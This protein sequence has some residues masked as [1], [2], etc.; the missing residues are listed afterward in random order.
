M[1]CCTFKLHKWSEWQDT[2][3][4]VDLVVKSLFSKGIPIEGTE[5]RVMGQRRYCRE[6]G[7]RKLR[8]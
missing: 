7:I 6:C 3:I 2:P 5:R 1:S 8:E 4:I